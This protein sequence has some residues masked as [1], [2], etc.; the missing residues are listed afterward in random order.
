MWIWASIP[1]SGVCVCVQSDKQ[2]KS[3]VVPDKIARCARSFLSRKEQKVFRLLNFTAGFSIPDTSNWFLFFRIPLQ[4]A[5]VM[6]EVSKRGH[7]C[8]NLQKLLSNVSFA[9]VISWWH[10]TFILDAFIGTENAHKHRIG[11]CICKTGLKFLKTDENRTPFFL[12][13][14]FISR[15]KYASEDALYRTKTSIFLR[16]FDY[17]S[18]NK[19]QINSY[20]YL[21]MLSMN[22]TNERAPQMHSSVRT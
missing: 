3:A 17:W 4:P 5:W 1:I 11:G 12:S 9:E 22:G 8:Q 16:Q 10:G 7:I 20:E 2:T 21:Q 19:L 15:K 14:C 13:M 6:S 18:M